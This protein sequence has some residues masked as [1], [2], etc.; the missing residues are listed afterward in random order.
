MVSF[1]CNFR[2]TV[3]A[4]DQQKLSI[5]L[6]LYCFTWVLLAFSTAVL[7]S[8][9]IG[10][11]YFITA[12]NVC[13]LL[14][15][16]VGIVEAMA[17]APG[18]EAETGVGPEDHTY[19]GGVRYQSVSTEEEVDGHQSSSRIVEE[20]EPTE[21]TPLVQRERLHPPS[22][23][24]QGASAWWILQ[25][26]L[27]VPFPVILAFHISVM[28]LAALDQTLTDGNS[29]ALSKSTSPLNVPSRG[30]LTYSVV[31]YSFVS[32][33]ALLLVFPIAPFS[34]NVHRWLTLLVFA[35][36]VL[37]TVY[38]WIE[39]PFSQQAP[40]KVYFVQTADLTSSG[41]GI[42]RTTTAL[43]GPNKFLTRY[44]LPELPSASG[45]SVKCYNAPDKVGLQTCTWEVEPEMV[46]SPG[47]QD[48]PHDGVNVPWV[49]YSLDR[50]E[51]NS[52]RI[53]VQGLN[54]RFC[55][56]EFTNRRISK[57]SV[58][59]DEDQGLQEGYEIPEEGIRQIQL[60]S[61]DFGKQFDVNVRWKDED[62]SEPDD[63]VQGRVSCGW[64]EYERATIGGGWSGGKIPALEEVIQYLPEW[65]VV[66]KSTSGLFH[67]GMAFSL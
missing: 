1:P 63:E 9:E 22:D 27:V 36:F 5:L 14:G 54:T 19:V 3:F 16:I 6:Q 38:T 42:D 43:T 47:G 34:I 66:S 46:P 41:T 44:I 58:V 65:A 52:A 15:C 11:T 48:T 12:W 7:R 39:F 57:F 50:T 8:A 24:P 55:T 21:T 37:S 17:S 20:P 10:S 32:L 60:W 61:R 26:L 28:S 2:N 67:A 45:K 31:A 13:A 64:D 35:I 4:P 56:L 23:E 33:L 62:V 25:L 40:L 53:T 59:G 49:S 51:T 18:V 30:H 29:P